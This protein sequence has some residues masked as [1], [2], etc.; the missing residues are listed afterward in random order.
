[1]RHL[2][3]KP[4]SIENLHEMADALNIKRCWHHKN[5]YDIPKRRIEEIAGKATLV[6]SREILAIIN[7]T[8]E[9]VMKQKCIIDDRIKENDEIKPVYING[10]CFTKSDIKEVKRVF[11][12]IA[13]KIIFTKEA[14]SVII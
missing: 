8:K 5:H 13:R 4:Y 1:M 2:V 11:E 6:S 14:I 7:P 3:C 10:K 9:K 12:N